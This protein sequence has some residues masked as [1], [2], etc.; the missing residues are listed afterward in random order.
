MDFQ[1]DYYAILGCAPNADQAVIQAAYRALAKKYHPDANQGSDETKAK[2]QELQEA[3]EVLSNPTKRAYYDSM[4]AG[5][6]GREYAPGEEHTD[7]SSAVNAELQKRWDIVK[8]YYADVDQMAVQLGKISPNLRLIFQLILLDT[9]TFKEARQ[10]AQNIEDIY[11]TR[12]FGENGD[13][14]S[15]AKKLLLHKNLYHHADALREL[16]KTI[17]ILGLEAPSEAI[18]EKL[19]E[20]YDLYWVRYPFEREPFRSEELVSTSEWIRALPRNRETWSIIKSCAQKSGWIVDEGFLG[21]V[22]FTNKATRER[23]SFGT[24]EQ[25]RK[26]LRLTDQQLITEKKRQFFDKYKNP[27]TYRRTD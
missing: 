27:Y 6:G 20:K 26:E 22:W 3:Y 13:I 21:A 10:I 25:A 23:N 17:A 12:Y 2:F 24:P 1:K 15:F 8:E 7:D 11:L 18:I 14:K 9:K 19:E 5:T 4:R 16:N